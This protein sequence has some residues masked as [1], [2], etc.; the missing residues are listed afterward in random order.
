MTEAEAAL[1]PLVRLATRGRSLDPSFDSTERLFLRFSSMTEDG[2]V[3][4]AS[5]GYPGS[6]GLSCNRERYSLPEDVL[7][8]AWP[9]HGIAAI[10]VE[11][12]LGFYNLDVRHDP[13]PENYAHALVITVCL[14]EATHVQPTQAV[15]KKARLEV[16]RLLAVLREPSIRS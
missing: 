13:L 10:D 8:P 2:Y 16:S 7:F 1:P 5:V 9:D 12:V 15:K 3:A 4:A 11:R 6:D 14:P